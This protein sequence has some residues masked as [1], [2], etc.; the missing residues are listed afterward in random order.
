MY[1][2]FRR[3]KQ[4]IPRWRKKSRRSKTKH[5]QQ[6]QILQNQQGS[7]FLVW[8]FTARDVPSGSRDPSC[9]SAN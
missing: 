9:A 1:V 7:S 4:L 2:Y 5:H 8:R 6:L 3:R